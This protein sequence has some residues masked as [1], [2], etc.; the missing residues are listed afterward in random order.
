MLGNSADKLCHSRSVAYKHQILGGGTYLHGYR[1]L[2]SSRV[3]LGLGLA[4][5][6]INGC[7][8]VFLLV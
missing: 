1:M 2:F 7:A 4:L 3:R 5:D 8:H 6:L